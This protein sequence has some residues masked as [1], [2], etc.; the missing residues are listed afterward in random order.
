[1]FEGIVVGAVRPSCHGEMLRT[2]YKAEDEDDQDRE[3]NDVRGIPKPKPRRDPIKGSVSHTSQDCCR[4]GKE[5]IEILN[6]SLKEA[7]LKELKTT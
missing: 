2:V 1:M 6:Q 3:D 4:S 5:K 7:I